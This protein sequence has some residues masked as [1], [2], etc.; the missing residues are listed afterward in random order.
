[1]AHPSSVSRPI[2]EHV[3]GT[4]LTYNSTTAPNNDLGLV[5]DEYD[6]TYRLCKYK[7]VFNNCATACVD[8]DVMVYN[9]KY[10]AKVTRSITSDVLANRAAGVAFGTI[11]ASAY[12]WIEV[13]G[14]H[15]AIKVSSGGSIA[16]GDSFVASATSTGLAIRNGAA[17]ATNAEH[18][19]VIG[20]AV[21]ADTTT[22][23]EGFIT[24]AA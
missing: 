15:D 2:G 12:G 1:M 24:L 4:V 6:T 9:D 16:S 18:I 8:G 14:Y 22:S 17:G 10:D 20:Q 11:A 23:V 5:R 7:M 3:W 13:Y 21:A 19:R